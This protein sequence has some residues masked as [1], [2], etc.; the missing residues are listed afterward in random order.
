MQYSEKMKNADMEI[1]N[2]Q[3]QLQE[4]AVSLYNTEEELSSLSTKLQELAEQSSA[5]VTQWKGRY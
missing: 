5:A 3:Y 1:S 4:K 2:L